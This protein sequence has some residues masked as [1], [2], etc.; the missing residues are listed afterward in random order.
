MSDEDIYPEFEVKKVSID[1][2]TLIAIS[3]TEVVKMKDLA[4]AFRENAELKRLIKWCYS[5]L[6]EYEPSG[7]YGNQQN[8]WDCVVRDF[9]GT[10]EKT[11]IEKIVGEV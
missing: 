6:S 3:N 4:N 9:G 1:A 8:I 10:P 7:G 2:K 11:A 5:R